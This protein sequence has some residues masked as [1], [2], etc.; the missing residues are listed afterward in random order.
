M[1]GRRVAIAGAVLAAGCAGMSEPECRAA[2]WYALG[3]RDALIYAR[4]P[5]IDQH[6]YACA[7]FGVQVAQKDYLDGWAV[8]EGERVRRM[9]GEGSGLRR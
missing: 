6:A 9:A 5:Q 7:K 2:N 4:R 8:G 1:S 3:E